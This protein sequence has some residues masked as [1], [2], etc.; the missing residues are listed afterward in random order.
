MKS[1]VEDYV[2]TW[3]YL[4]A[5]VS[6][7]AGDSFHYFL[8]TIP[9]YFP[10]FSLMNDKDFF[11][12]SSSFQIKHCDGC[13]HQEQIKT[14]APELHPLKVKEPMYM[15]GMDVIGPVKETA[16][17]NQYVLTLTDY[18]SK[19]VDLFPLKDKTGAGVSKG[20]TTFMQVR[21]SKL[22]LAK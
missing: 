22:N 15:V 3:K 11:I 13:Q 2:S 9:C 16:S 8:K 21:V 1:D 6:V 19:F 7:P 4:Q 12:F 14:Q 10:N 18:F 20:F 5:F 17:G